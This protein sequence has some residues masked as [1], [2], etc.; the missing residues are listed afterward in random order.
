MVAVRLHQRGLAKHDEVTA[1]IGD[2][3]PAAVLDQVSQGIL[4]QLQQD[5]RR[6]YAQIARAVG[7]SEAAV[8]QRVQRMVEAGAT[9]IAAISD[10]S[11]LG[12]SRQAM[13]GIATD[14]DPRDVAAA[15]AKMPAVRYLVLTAGAFD[16]LAEVVAADDQA[17]LGV[18]A[19]LRATSGVRSTQTFAYL[20]T[21]KRMDDWAM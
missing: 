8:R 1:S 10:P 5:G 6:P 21:A 7:L 2:A 17:L 13:L 9:R 16:M 19:S 14:G 15:I 18:I 11:I 20:E 12:L 3:R 4:R